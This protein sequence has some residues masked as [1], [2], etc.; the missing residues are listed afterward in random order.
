MPP[1]QVTIGFFT[2]YCAV[3][4][5]AFLWGAGTALGELPPYFVA[6]A[7]SS[8]GGMDEELEEILQ[9]DEEVQI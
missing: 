8:A 4:L 5:E 9:N 3:F 6:R 1:D 2:I 7:A